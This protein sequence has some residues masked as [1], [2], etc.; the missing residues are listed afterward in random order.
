ML[1]LFVCIAQYKRCANFR[2]VPQRGEGGVVGHH[3]CTEP[4]PL[5]PGWLWRQ[6][7][8]LCEQGGRAGRRPGRHQWSAVSGFTGV[9]LSSAHAHL[10]TRRNF[11]AFAASRRSRHQRLERLL[12][13]CTVNTQR[14][15]LIDNLR[16]QAKTQCLAPL[17]PEPGPEFVL[18]LPA[19]FS[20]RRA[21]GPTA[22]TAGLGRHLWFGALLH[23]MPLTNCRNIAELCPQL[24]P[25]GWE[26][27]AA[28]EGTPAPRAT[29]RHLTDAVRP[30]RFRPSQGCR[31]DTGCAHFSLHRSTP[32][33]PRSGQT[34]RSVPRRTAP[35]RRSW[36]CPC[37]SGRRRA[38][39]RCQDPPC[40]P[41]RRHAPASR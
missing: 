19:R 24:R 12:A 6:F 34:C 22:P 25:P 15:E 4:S 1:S 36:G 37:R 5:S 18:S 39:W 31:L 10:R 28:P 32:A 38:C 20:R 26:P 29:H 23:A 11:S 13:R 2:S 30:R 27:L 14:V 17:L 40:G 21:G 9:I 3:R 41:T 33:L 35:S 7:V 8:D 16:R